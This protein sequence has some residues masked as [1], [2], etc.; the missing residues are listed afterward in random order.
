MFDTIIAIGT[1]ALQIAIIIL[2]IGIITRAPFMRWIRSHATLIM[3]G[4][5]IGAALI[6][7]I[8]QY[9]FLYPPCLLCWYQRIAIF[10]I[11]IISCTASFTRSALLR[12]QVLVLSICG[13]A[14][15]LFHVF[16]EAFPSAGLDVCGTTSISCLTRYVYEFGYITI[17]VMSLT[18]LI[19][20]AILSSMRGYPH[21]HVANTRH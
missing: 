20:A 5:F 2:V 14:V 21:E 6:S 9:W 10:A 18:I 16:I 7:L 8:Y 1:I 12:T 17:P 3:R 15:A 11:A 4:T 19:F 13:G